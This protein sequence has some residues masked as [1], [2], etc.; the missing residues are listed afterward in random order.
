MI[1]YIPFLLVWINLPS[2]LIKRYSLVS[3]LIIPDYI[4]LHIVCHYI[5]YCIFIAHL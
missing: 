1:H 4:H 3:R 2:Y 5:S